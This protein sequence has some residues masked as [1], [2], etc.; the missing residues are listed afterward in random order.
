MVPPLGDAEVAKTAKSAWGYTERG[1]NWSA[2]GISLVALP[3]TAVE[4]LASE[5]P[6]AFAL[7]AILRSLHDPQ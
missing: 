7:L 2:A 4:E 1:L 5:N 6:D 3:R